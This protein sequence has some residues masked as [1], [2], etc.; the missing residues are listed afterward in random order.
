LTGHP[1]ERGV[2]LVPN[3]FLALPDEENDLSTARTVLVPVPYDGATSYRGGAREGPAAIISASRHLEDYDLESDQE[4]SK[5]GIY[6]HPE[7]EPHL[8]SPYE[9]V[10]RVY[11]VVGPL[12]SM[13]KLVGV[14]GGDHSIAVGSVRACLEQYADMSVLYLDAHADLRDEYQGTKYSHACTARRIHEMA[15][16]VQVGVRSLSTEEKD[17][18]SKQD[19]PVF[20]W[21]PPINIFQPENI[22]SL[23]SDNVYVSIDLDV[24][25]P[26]VMSAVGTPEPGGMVWQEIISLLR[27]VATSR[28]IVGFDV[29][30][31][32][33]NEGPLA[34]A[35]IAAKLVYK[36]IGHATVPHVDTR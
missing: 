19:I 29:V 32:S 25:D 31:L 33:P 10:E 16:L 36:L 2:P 23:L 27:Q 12:V 18:I 26:S 24:L 35:F 30:E 1:L 9:M 8:G 34:C 6:T 5:L 21:D 20:L 22:V 15:P 13:G 17:Y 14:L 28:R 11:Q 7:I 3:S 4:P